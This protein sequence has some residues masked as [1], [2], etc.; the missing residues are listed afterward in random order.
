MDFVMHDI[1]VTSDSNGAFL[2]E[3]IF[4]SLGVPVDQQRLLVRGV[5]LKDTQHLN[6][7][8]LRDGDIVNLIAN[9]RRDEASQ[10]VQPDVPRL[11]VESLPSSF[12]SRRRR[13]RLSR[14]RDLSTSEQLE[15]I[16]QNLITL[17]DL[18]K[19]RS[20]SIRSPPCI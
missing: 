3:A 10:E 17:E 15:A 8:G 5:L 16:R 18:L 7:I 9:P 2:K 20:L 4:I 1:E 13:R 12:F 6:Q 14:R 11:P 19:K